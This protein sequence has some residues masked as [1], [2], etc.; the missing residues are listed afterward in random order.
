[1]QLFLYHNLQRRSETFSRGRA[2]L[3]VPALR[4]KSR[5]QSGK[6]KT[7]VAEEKWPAFS[8]RNMNSM[9]AQ[10]RSD[11]LGRQ[12]VDR[13]SLCVSPSMWRRSVKGSQLGVGKTHELKPHIGTEICR[14]SRALPFPTLSARS[15]EPPAKQGPSK[16]ALTQ[17]PKQQ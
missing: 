9:Q 1:M 17:D 15:A 10:R 14:S 5:M 8:R 3:S 6:A 16:V 2:D 11:Y 12:P 4:R 13:D 7:G